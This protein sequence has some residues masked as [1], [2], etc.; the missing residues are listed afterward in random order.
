VAVSLMMEAEATSET[1]EN[2][3][4]TTRRNNIE[5]RLLNLL[6]YTKRQPNPEYDNPNFTVVKLETSNI[7]Q[8]LL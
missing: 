8:T 7:L 5:G 4:Q 6:D 3:Y 1:S 2:F